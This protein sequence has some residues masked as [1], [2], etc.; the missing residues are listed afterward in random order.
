MSFDLAG[1][2]WS[3]ESLPGAV[4]TPYEVIVEGARVLVNVVTKLDVIV[5]LSYSVEAGAV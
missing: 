5:V 4:E 2:L 1:W 3:D